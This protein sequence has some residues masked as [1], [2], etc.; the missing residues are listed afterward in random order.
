MISVLLMYTCL[1][2]NPD[3][4]CASREVW[5]EEIWSGPTASLVCE[6]VRQEKN[7]AALK[8]GATKTIYECESSSAESE[9]EEHVPH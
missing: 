1:A 7:E 9:G 2:S 3:G 4:S 6:S 5:E 8:M